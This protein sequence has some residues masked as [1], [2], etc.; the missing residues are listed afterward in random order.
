M[1]VSALTD[2]LNYIKKNNIARPNRFKIT[3]N[4]P[5]AMSAAP[6]GSVDTSAGEQYMQIVGD[7]KSLIG[8]SSLNQTSNDIAM[9]CLMVDMPSKQNSVTDVRYGTYARRVVNGRSYGEVGMTFLV[10]GNYAEKKFFDHWLNIIND[11]SNTSVEFYDN[12][13]SSVKVDCLDLQDNI[14]YTFTLDEA[15]PISIGAIRMDRTSQNSQMVLDVQWTFFR[16]VFDDDTRSLSDP[17]SG[18]GIPPTGIPGVGSGKNRLLAIPGLDSFSDAVKSA[19]S[20]VKGFNDQLQGV[21]AVANDVRSQVRDAKMQVLDG[22]KTINGT[23]KDFKAIAHVPTDVKNEV[24]GVL[25]DTKNQLGS[26]N[27]DLKNFTKYPT[28]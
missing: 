21:L 16:V 13:V 10:T 20:T 25:T 5:D 23:I 3:F 22:V 26:L 14:V 28:K 6:A 12:Y 9:T 11:E 17:Q 8:D 18:D 19:V 24:V 1:A 27:S 7:L 2:F 4:I 15:Y